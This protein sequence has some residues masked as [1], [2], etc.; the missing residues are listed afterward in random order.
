[1]A[2]MTLNNPGANCNKVGDRTLA[3]WQGSTFYHFTTY[4]MSP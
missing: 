4:D 1:M 2:R 3:L